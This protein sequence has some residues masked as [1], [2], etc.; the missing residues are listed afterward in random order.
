MSET[1][2]SFQLLRNE[3]EKGK[4]KNQTSSFD[5]EL[6]NEHLEEA[7]FLY[8][9]RINMLK[10]PEIHWQ[11]LA[12]IEDRL[13][14]HIDAL[15]IGGDVAVDICIKKNQE[16]EYEIIFPSICLFCRKNL[17]EHV[18]KILLDLKISN[19][20]ENQKAIS[21][22][23]KQEMPEQWQDKFITWLKN[24]K[25]YFFMSDITGYQRLPK[26]EDLIQVAQNVQEHE[27]LISI[28]RSI[29]RVHESKAEKWLYEQLNHQY[30][31]IA[32]EGAISLLR[33]GRKDI[34]DDL[35]KNLS[36]HNWPS[37]PISLTGNLN[38]LPVLIELALSD[39]VSSGVLIAL[40]LMGDISVMDILI[41]YLSD[42]TLAQSAS[43]ALNLVTGAQIYEDVFIP[44]EIDPDELF[45]EELE[46]FKKGELVNQWGSTVT[47]L[48]QQK[49]QWKDFWSKEQ[50]EFKHGIRYRDGK[51]Y[52]SDCLI[53]HLKSDTTSL[54][55]R[56]FEYDELLIQYRID[57]LFEVD[58]PVI[59]QKKALE[60]YKSNL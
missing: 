13:E 57:I 5:N 37:I 24:N 9:Q 58:M 54:M 3:M 38:L 15:T 31:P 23:L 56:Q 4:M 14:A 52:S 10:E 46:K 59:Q 55:I 28:I 43:I 18:Q 53:E 48:S 47:R 22:S 2:Q 33:L 40:G 36:V 44:D 7:A 8:K 1:G 49:K 41:D 29:G 27:C 25:F 50:T 26:G 11:D 20:S 12:E 60:Q 6:Y 34:I 39:R 21:D 30:A 35:T 17:M 32:L 19:N 45:D 42:T 16:Q 51:K